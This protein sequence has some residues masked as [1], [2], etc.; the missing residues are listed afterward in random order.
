METEN[1]EQGQP[2]TLG[3]VLRRI[4]DAQNAQRARMQEVR[5]TPAM[6]GKDH[7]STFLYLDSRIVDRG[8]K[9]S[10]PNMRTRESG[11]PTRLQ[12]GV[13]LQ[14]HDDYDCLDDFSANKLVTCSSDDNSADEAVFSFTDLGWTVAALV[15]KH[16]ADRGNGGDATFDWQAAI[17]Q[18]CNSTPE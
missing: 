13:E 8:G 9:L 14:G 5:R 4:D 11:Y 15:R 3:D 7:T 1:A 18:A 17:T 2:I 16:R 12:G 10:H 6:W